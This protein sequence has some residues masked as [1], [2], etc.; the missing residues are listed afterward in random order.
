MKTRE[1]KGN[2]HQRRTVL[3]FNGILQTV[4]IRNRWKTV[5]RT[6]M[7]IWPNITLRFLIL[8]SYIKV[9]LFFL[10]GLSCACQTS[11]ST[12]ESVGSIAICCCCWWEC[13]HH[14]EDCR[15]CSQGFWSLCCI[16]GA[17]IEWRERIMVS[18]Y[19]MS[20]VVRAVFIWVSRV[21]RILLWFC[22]SSLCHWLK[23]LASLSRPIRGKTQTNRDL[24][25]RVFP[26]LAPVTCVCFEFWL[27]Q[28][29]I[30]VRCDWLG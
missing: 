26:R 12:W 10:L 20:I 13:A 16:T 25:T 6:S 19:F 5:R 8:I 22:F 17:L 1:N 30:C 29:V 23:N 24:L 18:T 7:L 27:V 9:L 3:M 11:Y 21:I 14:T 4:T 2:D 15:C 28:W